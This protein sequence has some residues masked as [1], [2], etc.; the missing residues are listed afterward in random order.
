[1]GFATWQTNIQ[2]LTIIYPGHEHISLWHNHQC[3]HYIN[4]T[5]CNITTLKVTNWQIKIG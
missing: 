5:F 1:L 4:Y 3:T 2:I